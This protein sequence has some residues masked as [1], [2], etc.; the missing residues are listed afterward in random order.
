MLGCHTI[1]PMAETST[2]L[3]LVSV[4][5]P[6][7]NAASTLAETLDSV[8]AQTYPTLEVVVVDD[9]SKDDTPQVLE[10]YAGRVRAIRQP[11]GGLAAARNAGCRAAQGE[12][13]ALLD[14]DD[15]CMPERIGVQVG[16]LR[17]HP[18]VLL[19][20]SEFSAFDAR[21]E[22]AP[23]YA[24]R[25][26]SRLG[27]AR[28]GP[29]DFFAQHQSMDLTL[30]C[31]SPRTAEVYTGT[32][33]PAIALGN[34]VH[35]PTVM[36]RRG[37][38]AQAGF[39]DETIRNACDWEWL[40]RAARLGP[41]GYID[42]PLLRYRLLETSMSGPRHRLT[43]Y[44]DVLANLRRF[45]QA[46]PSL[47]TNSPRAYRGAIGAAQLNV[48]EALAESQPWRALALLAGA[49]TRGAMGRAWW[50]N[51]ARAL[52]PA[53]VIRRIRAVRAARASSAG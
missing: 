37:V 45:A 18:D 50:R 46:D 32:V 22:V 38:L 20:S 5:I 10:R 8:L 23:R 6:A 36:F 29:A 39:F 1:D 4:V 15:V 34:F 47:A 48:A 19:C 3:P 14:A 35:P 42:H 17:A 30:W 2:A 53:P 13:I 16:F 33:Y 21:G 40:V 41:F 9:G 27:R 26:Y 12:F 28:H 49:A 43:L 24:A 25:Y 44:Q 7:Y 11:N 31:A 52:A 51:A